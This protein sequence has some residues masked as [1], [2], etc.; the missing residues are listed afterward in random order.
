MFKKLIAASIVLAFF[1][2]SSDSNDDGDDGKATKPSSSSG[3]ANSSSSE[4]PGE[5]II[6]EVP[7]VIASFNSGTKSIFGTYGYGF[8]IKAGAKEDLTQF[9]DISDPD[10]PATSQTTA[11]PAKCELDKTTA[12]LQ[13]KLTNRY[14][15]LHYKVDEIGSYPNYALELTGYNLTE[16]GDQAALGLNVGDGADEGKSIGDLGIDTLNGAIAFTYKYKGGAHA[17]RLAA[18][19]D[20]FWF[21]EFPASTGTAAT[22]AKISPDELEGAGDFEGVPFDLSKVAKFF[23]AVEYTETGSNQGSLNID[24][25]KAIVEQEVEQ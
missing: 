15:D 5:P 16:E 24:D 9:W 23:W 13:N 6:E 8:T 12:I 17:F 10:C 19:D 20:D 22:E 2:C 25:F 21:I 18:N 7:I 1:A 11:P 14:S 4:G 3:G